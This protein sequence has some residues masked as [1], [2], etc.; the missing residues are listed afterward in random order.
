MAWIWGLFRLL[1]PVP[2]IHRLV[3]TFFDYLILR[4][5]EIRYAKPGNVQA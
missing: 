2:N 4:E 3:L 5:D 1:R